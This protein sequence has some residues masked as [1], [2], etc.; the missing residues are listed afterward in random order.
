MS[1]LPQRSAF[2]CSFLLLL[3]ACGGGG[4]SSSALSGSDTSSPPESTS[5]SHHQP[6]S[7]L[8]SQQN[9][10]RTSPDQQGRAATVAANTLPNF[11]SVTQSSNRGTDGISSDAATA[12]FDGQN[13][14]VTIER[15]DGSTFVLDTT[16]DIFL[17][18]PF[19][20]HISSH[21]SGQEAYVG[22]LTDTSF[23]L[24]YVGSSWS[25]TS[26][27][28]AGGYWMRANGLDTASPTFEMGAFV[29]GPEISQSATL[30]STGTANYTGPTQGFYYHEYQGNPL[31]PNGTQ[32]IG[33]V[34]GIITLT[35]DFE[36]SL[37]NGCVGCTQ[38]SLVT[39][40]AVDPQGQTYFE[41]EN[42]PIGYRVVYGPTPIGSDGS[43][44]GPNVSLVN[45]DH[46]VTESSG[47]WGGQFSN[48]PDAEGDPRLVTGTG[49]GDYTHAN[50][51]H[52]VWI[53]AFL[54]TK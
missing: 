52:G 28:L 32:E 39:G 29:D 9:V 51:T 44:R 43:F 27:F 22:E 4:G 46:P 16:D 40:V 18:A 13:V 25:S 31:V 3:T 8:S 34:I 20:P 37:I 7:A 53:G 35:V 48:I 6:V 10:Q 54:G 11:G 36:N 5:A 26:D 49:G 2:V 33:E 19:I 21:T 42:V 23:Y 30:P 1:H 12:V 50:G 45:P 15:L 14:Q 41:F 38:R 17:K 24:A 47:S